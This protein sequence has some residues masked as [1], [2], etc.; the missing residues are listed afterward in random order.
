MMS[1][2]WSSGDIG[3]PGPLDVLALQE[4]LQLFE[5]LHRLVLYVGV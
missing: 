3:G 1:G 4:P 5:L 2:S